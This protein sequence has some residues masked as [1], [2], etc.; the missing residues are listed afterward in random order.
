MKKNFV[1]KYSG[2]TKILISGKID[3]ILNDSNAIDKKAI[4]IIKYNLIFTFGSNAER[5][6]FIFTYYLNKFCFSIVLY[7]D[8][9]FSI[10]ISKLTRSFF[11]KSA[12][13]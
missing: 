7:H 1:L 2:F 11:F 4:Q 13:L 3:T 6:I 9:N 5:T 12:K 10:S 8:I